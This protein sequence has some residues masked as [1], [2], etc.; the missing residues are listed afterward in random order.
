M[1]HPSSLGKVIKVAKKEIETRKIGQ[2]KESL[3]EGKVKTRESTRM[4]T[5]EEAKRSTVIKS[6]E[7]KRTGNAKAP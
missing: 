7:S 6:I 1:E 3:R 2:L 5:R 4:K